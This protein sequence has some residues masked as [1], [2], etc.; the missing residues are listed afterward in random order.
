LLHPLFSGGQN[1][2]QL[3]EIAFM[4]YVLLAVSP[5][6]MLQKRNSTNGKINLQI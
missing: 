5:F 4:N 3:M 1:K 6:C 2:N